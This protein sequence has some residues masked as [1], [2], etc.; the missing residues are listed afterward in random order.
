[1][2]VLHSCPNRESVDTGLG[3]P[4]QMLPLRAVTLQVGD[5]AAERGE[6][7]F[8]KKSLVCLRHL[9]PASTPFRVKVFKVG[10]AGKAGRDAVPSLCL[11]CTL[12][13]S[14]PTPEPTRVPSHPVFLGPRGFPRVWDF[15]AQTDLA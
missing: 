6:H 2:R 15:R 4:N 7:P 3:S 9:E 11:E 13:H 1:M 12:P 10:W 14:P 5:K 8:K